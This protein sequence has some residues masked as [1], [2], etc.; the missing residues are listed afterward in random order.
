MPQETKEKRPY[1]KRVY[2]DEAELTAI[3]CLRDCAGLSMIAI[4]RLLGH[5]DSSRRNIEWVYNKNKLFFQCNQVL[6]LKK[7]KK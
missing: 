6:E 3:V 7:N 4:T 1:P 2:K 5:N